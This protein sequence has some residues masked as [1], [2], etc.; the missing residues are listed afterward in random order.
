MHNVHRALNRALMDSELHN[1]RKRGALQLARIQE[2]AKSY[3]TTMVAA[4]AAAVTNMPNNGSENIHV[5]H[6]G[7]INANNSSNNNSSSNRYYYNSNSSGCN[8]SNRYSSSGN[9]LLSTIS[10]ISHLGF[11]GNYSF[12]MHHS[13]QRQQQ[14]QQSQTS[15]PQNCSIVSKYNTMMTSCDRNGDTIAVAANLVDGGDAT[16]IMGHN[17]LGNMDIAIR[18]HKVTILFNEV[19]R[20]AKR[21]E[22]LT[23]QRREQLRELTRQRAL[24][25]EINEGLMTDKRN[26]YITS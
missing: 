4:A 6:N 7:N 16:D 22:Q 9:K 1:L 25:D 24:E 2:L 13:Q 8:N 10:S 14:I 15:Q 17:N 26:R 21:L 23:E 12:S 11:G 5:N 20:A 18:L 19:D 3:A